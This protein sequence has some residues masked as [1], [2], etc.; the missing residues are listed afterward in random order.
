MKKSIYFYSLFAVLV[1]IQCTKKEEILTPEEVQIPS[2]EIWAT[3][4]GVV[5]KFRTDGGIF[6]EA[7]AGYLIPIKFLSIYRTISAQD[8]RSLQLR[9]TIDLDNITTPATISQNIKI[10]YTALA[11]GQRTYDAQGNNLTFRL[12][13]TKG[14]IIKAT[15]SGTFVNTANAN[16]K[17]EIKNGSINIAFKRYN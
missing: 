4:N 2:N 13:D 10:T 11:G 14:D 16:D 8:R 7:A 5:V 9:A 6:E 17:I 3:I 12:L 1:F 15:F